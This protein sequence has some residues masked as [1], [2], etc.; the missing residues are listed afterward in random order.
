MHILKTT[1]KRWDLRPDGP[2]LGPVSV[3]ESDVG[4]A[5]THLWTALQTIHRAVRLSLGVAGVGAELSSDTMGR[6]IQ[7]ALRNSL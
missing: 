6:D 4:S 3:D 1:F 7:W 5:P 2:T